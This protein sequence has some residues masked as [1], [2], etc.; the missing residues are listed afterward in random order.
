MLASQIPT[1]F[2]I[3]FGNN[4]AAGTIRAVPTADQTAT[5]PGAASLT[6]GFPVATG[7]PI[8]AGGIPPSM[9]DFNGI[10]NQISAWA[11]W[12]A[13]AGLVPYDATFSSVVGG[14]PQGATVL[15][16]TTAARVWISTADN[17]TTNPDA[18]TAANWLPLMLLSDVTALINTLKIPGSTP[19]AFSTPGSTTL[20]VSANT[21][22][23][24]FECRGGGGGGGGCDRTSAAA[25][26]GGGGGVA[27]YKSF[28]A[29]ADT[30]LT[31]N[32]GASGAGGAAG[33][34]NGG[35]GGT[36]SVVVQSGS[37]TDVS[38][39]PFNVGATLCAATG[40][41]G[42]LGSSGGSFPS[43]GGA[44]GVATGGGLNDSGDSGGTAV[45]TLGSGVYLGGQGGLSSGSGS[46]QYNQASP[47]VS[48]GA[49]GAGGSGSS[50]N[51]A[52]GNGGPGRV[53]I[54]K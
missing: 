14:Y 33:G 35:A 27:R 50:A 36:T 31:I 32:V 16:G 30:I 41:S 13:A 51:A 19:Y 26:G 54:F 11:R 22:F 46:P 15:S 40:G 48:A 53:I 9:Q 25:P 21:T 29:T 7:Q 2:P 5:S 43:P 3:P 34:G 17:N 37:V 38:G 45:G 42:G 1:K 10:L 52:G 44:G 4:A 8:A 47:G 49:P 6:T 39:N 28:T 23:Q 18:S 24:I 20:S 12:Q